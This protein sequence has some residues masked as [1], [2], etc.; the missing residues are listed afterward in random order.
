LFST[1]EALPHLQDAKHSG[2][3]LRRSQ[4]A[5]NAAGRRRA[6]I[7]NVRDVFIAI[8]AFAQLSPTTAVGDRFA[9]REGNDMPME[10]K[11]A[12]APLATRPRP[13]QQ[14]V[15]RKVPSEPAFKVL[16]IDQTT[17]DSGAN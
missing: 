8:R 11:G 4:R 7:L 10:D 17:E 6:I 12:M 2:V 16:V 14:R 13:S 5:F 15:G 3:N 9:Q 1:G